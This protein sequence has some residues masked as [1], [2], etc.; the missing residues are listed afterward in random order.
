MTASTPR[1][2]A[3]KIRRPSSNTPGGPKVSEEKILVTV[4]LRPLS[5]KEQAAYDRSEQVLH[6]G[7]ILKQIFQPTMINDVQ[8]VITLQ[9]TIVLVISLQG[10][11]V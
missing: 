2:P 10:E 8:N 11:L 6:M 3:S 4:R 1:T 9:T 5:P 7:K